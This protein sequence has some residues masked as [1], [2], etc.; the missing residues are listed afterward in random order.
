M[1]VV[2]FDGSASTDGSTAILL[3]RAIAQL[4][5]DGIEAELL[6]LEKNPLT[7]CCA[8]GQC[9]HKIDDRC[10]LPPDDGLRRCAGKMIAADGI[11]I[12]S[13]AYSAGCSP[14]TQVLMQRADHARRASDPHL[15][16]K[17]GAA[18]IS[19]G[20]A[21]AVRA[22]D[23]INHWFQSNEMIVVESG[24][25]IVGAGRDVGA[26]DNDEAGLAMMATLGRAM[27]R[28]LKLPAT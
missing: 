27:A 15:T 6:R 2:A 25:G 17:V 24:S 9:A 3:R 8:C 14:A 16:G 20:G 1:K 12:G 21:G 23:R 11:I 18:V 19:G 26:A 13:P 28:M 7:G 4:E 10:S 22:L 5:A